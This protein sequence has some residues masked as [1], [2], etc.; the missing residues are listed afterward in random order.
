MA[1]L[2]YGCYSLISLNISSNFN[3]SNVKTM[4]SMFRGCES[5]KYLD[6]SNFETNNV[7]NMG[8]MFY[9]CKSLTSL[10]FS[11]FETSEVK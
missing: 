11:N 5:L 4:E 1:R 2:F 7:E 6:I 3:T 10:N 9:N 8:H